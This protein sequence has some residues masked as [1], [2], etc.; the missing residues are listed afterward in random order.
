MTVYLVGP[1][2]IQEGKEMEGEV[3]QGKRGPKPVQGA[4]ELLPLKLF[5]S[6]RTW[7]Q[8]SA[9]NNWQKMSLIAGSCPPLLDADWSLQL[10]V[11]TS[12]CSDASIS[13][14]P[15]EGSIGIILTEPCNQG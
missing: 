1:H 9:G 8:R 4:A 6:R 7:K 12:L 10:A 13:A 2:W 3:G 14:H 15:P 11:L 5:L